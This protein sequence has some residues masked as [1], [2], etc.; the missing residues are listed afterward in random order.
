MKLTIFQNI[1]LSHWYTYQKLQCSEIFPKNSYIFGGGFFLA[2][3]LYTCTASLENV[4]RDYNI[5][6]VSMSRVLKCLRFWCAKTDEHIYILV[7]FKQI[8]SLFHFSI[9]KFIR[10]EVWWQK[11]CGK[12]WKER[13][14]IIEE[15]YQREEVYRDKDVTERT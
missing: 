14:R 4:L 8:I 3:F 15:K 13:E 9:L 12:T 10:M 2:G 7:Y 5:L 6:I 11:L 1:N